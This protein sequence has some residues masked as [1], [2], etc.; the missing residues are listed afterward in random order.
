[1]QAIVAF[2][3][4]ITLRVTST[5]PEVIIVIARRAPRAL[6]FLLVSL[7]LPLFSLLPLRAF[8]SL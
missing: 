8:P 2:F 3:H 4:R 1:M 5:N 6:L 7:L